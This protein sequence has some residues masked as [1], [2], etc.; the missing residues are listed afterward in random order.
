[1][2]PRCQ[3]TYQTLSL[4]YLF[5]HRRKE[6]L[7]VIDQWIKLKS[8]SAGI[9]G[10]LGFCLICAGEY[11]R[12]YVMLSE[13]IQLNPYYQ[14]WFNAGLSIYHFQKSEYEDA[15]YWAEKIQ[16]QSIPWELILKTAAY[17]EMKN[18]NAARICAQELLQA[19]PNLSNSLKPIVGSFLQSEEMVDRLVVA[20]KKVVL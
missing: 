9:A 5:Q 18:F 20:L 2:D 11:D 19:V 14:W 1:M 12:G 13:S 8:S 16:R 3:H 15:V 4:A 10:G 17:A 7:H 6:C